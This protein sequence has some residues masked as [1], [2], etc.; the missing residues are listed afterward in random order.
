MTV[1][2]AVLRVAW[3]EESIQFQDFLLRDGPHWSDGILF[4]FKDRKGAE[5][6]AQAVRSTVI[7][8]EVVE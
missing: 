5:R 7:E 3:K 1:L 4:V 2:W 8:L 6:Y